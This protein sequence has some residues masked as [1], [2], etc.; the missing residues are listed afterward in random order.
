[1]SFNY[2]LDALVSMTIYVFPK[3][4]EARKNPMSYLQSKLQRK[5]SRWTSD[6]TPQE[7]DLKLL[8]CTANIGNAEPT[9]ESMEAWIPL[10]GSCKVVTNLDNARMRAGN[11]D[12]IAIGMQES[13]WHEKGAGRQQKK[14][15][16]EE[17]ILSKMICFFDGFEVRRA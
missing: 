14:E 12:I 11:F 1:M 5:A 4:A 3:L 6:T 10:R 15:V 7:D 16:N 8:V 2:S 17:D 9:L 13:T